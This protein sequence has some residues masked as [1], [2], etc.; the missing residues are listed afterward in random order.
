M[1]RRINKGAVSVI[2]SGKGKTVKKKSPKCICRKIKNDPNK[3]HLLSWNCPRH[4]RKNRR[5]IPLEKIPE[6]KK[7]HTFSTEM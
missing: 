4:G 5:I 7:H 1:F 3:R 6:Q 2:I